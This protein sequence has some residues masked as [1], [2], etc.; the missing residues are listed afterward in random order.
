M[1]VLSMVLPFSHWILAGLLAA[2]IVAIA[3]KL[4]SLSLSGAVAAVLLGTVIVGTGGWWC[5]VILVA[6]FFSSSL[7]SRSSPNRQARGSRRDWVQVL[8]NGWGLLFGCALFAITGWQPWLGFGIGAIAAATADTWSSELGRRNPS[9]PRLITTGKV[10][11]PGRSGAISLYGTVASIL[12]AAFI[13]LLGASF[14]LSNP[15]TEVEGSTSLFLGITIAGIS[16][17][18]VDSLLGATFQEQRWCELCNKATEQNP[19]HCGSET[20]YLRGVSGFNNDVVNTL[21]VLAGALI[22]MVWSIL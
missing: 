6:F 22:G 20:R 21:C 12:G 16:G 19:H 9:P 13:A 5:G 4:R 14:G 8:A 11:E 3:F 10:V 18:V 1:I 17:S 2:M 7:L 15:L